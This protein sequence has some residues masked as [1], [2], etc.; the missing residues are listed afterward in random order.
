[1][2][3]KSA[4]HKALERAKSSGWLTVRMADRLACRLLGLTLVEL[5]GPDAV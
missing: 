5:W 1:V 4:E 3:Y 2:R